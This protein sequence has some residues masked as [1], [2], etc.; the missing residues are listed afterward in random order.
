MLLPILTLH[1]LTKRLSLKPKLKVKQFVGMA[2]KSVFLLNHARFV[3][4]I[5][6]F[7]KV[8]AHV[9]LNKLMPTL[10]SATP[11]RMELTGI[12]LRSTVKNVRLAVLHAKIFLHRVQFANQ[13]M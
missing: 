7:R 8:F 5:L 10:Q 12:R 13:T 1:L 3:M 6:R 4:Q 2:A 11:A 9:R